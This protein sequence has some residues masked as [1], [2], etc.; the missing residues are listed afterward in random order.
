MNILFV[1]LFIRQV[2]SVTMKILITGA[3]GF[4]GSFLV[5]KGVE[6]GYE[7]WAGMRRGSSRR[8]ITA[9]GVSFIE[10]DLLSP[11]DLRRRLSAFKAKHGAWDYVIHAAGVTKCADKNE[12]YEVN[13]GGTINLA[14]AL[15]LQGMAPKKFI[16]ISSL[17]IYGP[18]REKEPFAPITENDIPKP[19]TIYGKSKLAAERFIIGKSGIPFMILRPTGV[20]GPRERDYFKMVKSAS[21]HFDFSAGY[22]P[23]L[24]TFIYVKDLVKAV[25]LALESP[26]VNRCYLVSEPQGYNSSSFSD[27]I[28]SSLGKRFI[29]HI[30]AP[31]WLLR[32]VS[33]CCERAAALVGR[34]ST[35][36]SDKY[37]IMKQ[38]NWL[39]DTTAIEKELGFKVDYPLEKGVEEMIGWYKQNGRI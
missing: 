15:L 9:E 16:Y 3:S 33:F 10:L 38:R 8:N 1:F 20:Y 14:E 27:Y 13:E 4:I 5:E 23:Q 30:K 7:V 17:S 36:N 29:I 18:I 37:K 11:A 35:L 25:Y 31:L 12:F 19:N 39:C 32:A 24:I 2:F 21:L 34:A 6:K 28:A 26:L 22:R